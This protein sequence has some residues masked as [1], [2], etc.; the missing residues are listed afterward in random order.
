MSEAPTT[1]VTHD[2][3]ISKVSINKYDPFQLKGTVDDEIYYVTTH[4]YI[5]PILVDRYLR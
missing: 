2:D 3:L 5:T 1:G 4:T